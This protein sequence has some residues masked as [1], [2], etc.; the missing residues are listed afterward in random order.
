MSGLI[1]VHM[2]GNYDIEIK[3]EN[4]D[5]KYNKRFIKS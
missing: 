5:V 1:F 4:A 2:P 3:N